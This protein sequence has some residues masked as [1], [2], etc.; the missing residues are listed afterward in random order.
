MTAHIPGKILFLAHARCASHSVREL[1]MRA[2]AVE[3]SVPRHAD[4]ERVACH[5]ADTLDDGGLHAFMTGTKVVCMVR[6][7]YDVLARWRHALLQ[8]HR[9]PAW[10]V[11]SDPM[12]IWLR[13]FAYNIGPEVCRYTADGWKLFPHAQ[14]ADLCLRYGRMREMEVSLALMFNDLGIAWPSRGLRH[15]NAS[16]GPFATSTLF[17]DRAVERVRDLFGAE[18]TELQYAEPWLPEEEG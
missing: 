11:A 16:A 17:N 9:P 10:C 18:M 7:H 6:N 1:L 13:E 12:H 2:G 14:H 8:E 4:Y 5:M 15:I 3:L